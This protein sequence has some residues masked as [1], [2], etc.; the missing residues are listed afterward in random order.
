MD[1][2]REIGHEMLEYAENAEFTAQ[3][4]LID[5][6]F[7]FIY[8]ASKRMSLRAITRWLEENHRIKIS[9]NAVAKAMRNQERYWAGL[10][11]TVEPSARVMADAYGVPPSRV[12]D[13]YEYFRHLETEPPAVAAEDSDGIGKELRRLA[14]AVGLIRNRW[15]SLPDDVRNQCRRHFVGVFF[16]GEGLARKGVNNERKKRTK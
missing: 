15:Y 12:L 4:G 8:A 9:A 16:D 14:D 2:L 13:D 1:R 6:L 5:E 10:V 3:H 7:P 11:E